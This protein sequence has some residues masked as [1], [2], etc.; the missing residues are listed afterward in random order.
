MG[1]FSNCCLRCFSG[2]WSQLCSRSGYSQLRL[3]RTT[4][5][6][7]GSVKMSSGWPFDVRGLNLHPQITAAPSVLEYESH[8]EICNS[9]MPPQST[10]D[11]TFSLLPIPFFQT[12]KHPASLSVTIPSPSPL[13]RQICDL[14]DCLMNTSLLF[15]LASDLMRIR[16]MNLVP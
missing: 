11:F 8:E 15:I 12:S 14:L 5:P 6:P 4:D 16:Q 10:D 3:V 1:R 2:T 7:A 9:D 13:R